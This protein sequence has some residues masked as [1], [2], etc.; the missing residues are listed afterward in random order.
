MRQGSSH[1]DVSKERPAFALYKRQYV[2]EEF[3]LEEF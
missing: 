2:V 3:H 1:P